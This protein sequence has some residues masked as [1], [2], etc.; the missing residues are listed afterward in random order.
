MVD[1]LNN[2][3][4]LLFV[5]PFFGTILMTGLIWLLGRNDS[6]I[7]LANASVGAAFAWIS[8]LVLGTPAFPPAFNSSAILSATVALLI[9]GILLDLFLT[10]ET[11]FGRSIETS[12]FILSAIG[13]VTWMQ[14]GIDIWSIP[15]LIGWGLTIFN[16]QRV[17]TRTAPSRGNSGNW[18]TL[19]IVLASLGLG[20]I[21]WISDIVVDRDL[22]FGLA[23]SALGFYVWNWPRPRLFFGR[24]ILLA[25]GGGMLM[26]ALR[27]LEQAPPLAPAIILLGFIFFIDSALRNLPA[28]FA[29]IL[30]ISPSLTIIVLAAIPI[31]LAAVAAVIAIE[32]QIN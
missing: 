17:G 21:A 2:P 8:A 28:R 6:G 31:L 13:A 23:A 22:A 32:I 26:I 18:A 29:T 20:I 9:I 10:A 5:L 30:K 16:L 24:S 14:G 12:A 15:I 11:K 4:I 3:I 19:L 27:L 1:L 25:G 7:A